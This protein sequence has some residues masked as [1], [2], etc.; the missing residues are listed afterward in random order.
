MG[1]GTKFLSYPEEMTTEE[2]QE[3]MRY[4]YNKLED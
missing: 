3:F 1:E 4:N 2:A